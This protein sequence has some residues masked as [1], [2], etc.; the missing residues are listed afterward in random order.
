MKNELIKTIKTIKTIKSIKSN[1]I[2][3][4]I[5]RSILYS[6]GG[7]ESPI[8][9]VMKN[10]INSF[11]FLNEGEFHIR[12]KDFIIMARIRLKYHKY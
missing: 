3:I 10:H 11:N 2:P 7:L 4:E 8:G 1:K 5:I 6:Y 12:E 9:K